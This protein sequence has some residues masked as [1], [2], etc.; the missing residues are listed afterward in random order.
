MRIWLIWCSLINGAS[1]KCAFE[2][3]DFVP[4]SI[5]HTHTVS[6]NGQIKSYIF[7]LFSRIDLLVEIS[8]SVEFPYG[9][10]ANHHPFRSI[11]SRLRCM[12]IAPKKIAHVADSRSA[13]RIIVK[14]SINFRH[15]TTAH[16][17]S[18]QPTKKIL[19]EQIDCENGEQNSMKKNLFTANRN[20]EENETEKDAKRKSRKQNEAAMPA[21]QY[22][23]QRDNHHPSSMVA[24]CVTV[25]SSW[26]I[27]ETLLAY[28]FNKTL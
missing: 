9:E 16:T 26:S 28:K 5:P 4:D 25:F 7:C 1:A 17:S 23:Q 12:L 21:F 11:K 27:S 3:A 10:S 14:S 2:W 22:H 24:H 6:S 8:M 15:I 20:L 18:H 19:V 13:C